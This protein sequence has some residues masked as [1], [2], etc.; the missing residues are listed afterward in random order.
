MS[1]DPS[2]PAARSLT[3]RKRERK[4]R[5]SVKVID[6]VA[7]YGITIGGLGV[8][9][10]LAAI[11]IF[12]VVVVTPLF[13]DAN[14]DQAVVSDLDAQTQAALDQPA[15]ASQPVAMALDDNLKGVWTLDPLGNLRLY[16]IDRG[17]ESLA[18]VGTQLLSDV[19]VTAVRQAGGAVGIGRADGTVIVGRI[20]FEVEYPSVTPSAL[21]SLTRDDP[22]TPFFGDDETGLAPAVADVS[23][24]ESLRLT[25]AVATLSEPLDLTDESD[26]AVTHIDYA[27]GGE[28]QANVLVART[29]DGKLYWARASTRMDRRTGQTRTL[30]RQYEL[31]TTGVEGAEVKAVLAG[32]NGRNSYVIYEDG[33]LA[34]FDTSDFARGRALDGGQ[35]QARLA[36]VYQTLEEGRTVTAARMLLGDFTIVIGD[37]GGGISGW[38][39]AQSEDGETAGRW[40]VDQAHSL[41]E[42]P[43]AIRTI[44][45][46]S[47]D[48]QFF[49]G[50]DEGNLWLRHMTS[51]TTQAKLVMPDQGRAVTSA[52]APPMNALAAVSASGGFVMW[53]LENPHP[54]GKLP[55]LFAPVQYEGRDRPGFVWQSSSAGDAAEPKYSI[56]PLVWGTLK[57][58]LYA[59]LFATPIAILAAIYSSEFMQPKVRSVVKPSIEMMAGL[60]SVVLGYIAAQVL[61]P[62]AEDVLGGLLIA[63]ASVP[64]GVMVFGFLWQLVPPSEV[65][66]QSGRWALGG[67]AIAGL[68][69]IAY[70]GGIPPTLALLAWGVIALVLVVIVLT[71]GEEAG[72]YMPFVVMAELVVASVLVG[73]AMGPVF[74]ALFFGGDLKAWLRGDEAGWVASIASEQGAL[75]FL[76]DSMTALPGWVL[77]LTPLFVVFLVLGFNLYVRD[78]LAMF[79]GRTRSRRQLAVADLIRF[80]VVGVL[81]V[82]LATVVGSL[83]SLVGWDLR[84]DVLGAATGGV[85]EGTGIF[86]RFDPRNA[87]NVGM[88]M[89]FAVIPIIYTVSE[90][91]LSSVPNTLRSASLGAGAT[92]W[93]TAIRVVLPVAASGIFSACMI[94]LGRAAGETMI[95]LMAAGNTPTMHLNVFDGMRT[96]SANIATEMP[97]A[98]VGGTLYR[99]LFLTALVLFAMT[100]VVN[101][102]AEVVRARFRKRAFQL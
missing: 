34:W 30:I 2:P 6:A 59:M 33:S 46:S 93:Q 26:A 99:V 15:G 41:T 3:G 48:R 54:D 49:T 21:A 16:Q 78:R 38:F 22:P 56:M 42:Q 72:G 71:R 1:D 81:G 75:A 8:I 32:R 44:S 24:R 12:L 55:A 23:R 87:L 53:D 89:G 36:G 67:W 35:P 57:A 25:R 92:P 102:L 84:G 64:V 91:A 18:F 27:V 79:D 96:L 62:Y 94:G 69:G 76:P 60:P 29:E 17:N 28:A 88:I 68:A 63:F 101:T 4:T 40:V 58:T 97:E 95:V 19:E 37:S 61:A 51:G 85:I 10:A 5:T 66:R 74:E 100:F 52:I 7:K 20:D 14:V 80:A 86:G 50:D 43:A 77:L 82:A 13:G 70:F 83:T 31:P 98:P 11:L 90:D 39:P 9:A 47:R 45:L 65:N 73:L